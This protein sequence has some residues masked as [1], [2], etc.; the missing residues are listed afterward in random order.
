[1][2]DGALDKVLDGLGCEL[3]L[4]ALLR[5]RLVAVVEE[6][7]QQGLHQSVAGVLG[8]TGVALQQAALQGS[9][10]ALGSNTNDL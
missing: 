1:M 5:L 10:V 4:D 2:V 3:L 9:G 7:V 6:L 8:E